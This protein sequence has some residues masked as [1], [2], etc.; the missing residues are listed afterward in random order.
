MRRGEKA[1]PAR[2]PGEGNR[3][4]SR[5]RGGGGADAGASRGRK[6]RGHRPRRRGVPPPPPPRQ[7]TP[8][9]PPLSPPR[10]VNPVM[11][12]PIYLL[13]RDRGSVFVATPRVPELLAFLLARGVGA[14]RA[15]DCVIDLGACEDLD[16]VEALLAEWAE[17]L[18]A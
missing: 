14:R 12:A 17:S 6:C 15:S 7:V 1:G 18:R 16:R 11:P 10:R 13:Y 2:P 3:P 5:P 9:R 8:C 4:A